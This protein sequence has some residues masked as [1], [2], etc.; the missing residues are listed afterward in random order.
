[1]DDDAVL[2]ALGEELAREDPDLAARL[3]AA[4]GVRVRPPGRG[5]FWLV[6]AGAVVAVAATF[7]FGPAVFGVMAVLVL[8][9]CPFA[10]SHYLPDDGPSS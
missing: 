3:S 8:I 5:A 2:R 10:V 7:L 4:P 6:L 1:M 9:G